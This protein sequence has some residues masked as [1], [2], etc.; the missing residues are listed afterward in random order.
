MRW[1]FAGP[2]LSPKLMSTD[3]ESQAVMLFGD[4]GRSRI[5]LY[6]AV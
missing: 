1:Q 4:L 6:A 5:L 3:L 2:Y